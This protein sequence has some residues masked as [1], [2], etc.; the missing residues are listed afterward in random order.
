MVIFR[1]N[2]AG[3]NLLMAKP[4]TNCVN[5]IKKELEY[6]NY[7]LNKCY[8]TNEDGEFIEYKI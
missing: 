7:K 5:Y 3:T 4:C 6:K 8:F 1:V 2:N